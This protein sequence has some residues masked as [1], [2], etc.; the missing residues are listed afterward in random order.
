MLKRS[1]LKKACI[2]YAPNYPSFG[3]LGQLKIGLFPDELNLS[4]SIVMP[5][6]TI[7]RITD[8]I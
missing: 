6:R 2:E 3:M 1:R 7:H 5:A 8:Q 4:A